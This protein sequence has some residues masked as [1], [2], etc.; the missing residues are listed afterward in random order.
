MLP[1]TD[2]EASAHGTRTPKLAFRP[3]VEGLRAVA[4][5][6]VVGYHAGLP[7]L[8]GG[9][10]G[11]DVFFVISGFLITGLLLAEVQR[12]GRVSLAAFWARRARR[13]LP[14]AVL[15]LVVT[16]VASWL[17]IP[18]IDHAL[19]GGDIVAAGVYVANLRF[20][21]QA[22]DYLGAD[23][24]PSPVLH[25]WSLGV[26]EQF[27]LV[28][29]LLVLAIGVL[30][31][32]RLVA[33]R[34]QAA[35]VEGAGGAAAR[36]ARVA[37][38]VAVALAVVGVA[39]FLYSLW[40]TSESEPWAFFGTPAR[41]WEFAV[42]GLLAVASAQRKVAAPLVRL[43]LGWLGLLVVVG[44]AV[45]LDAD[46]P[47]PG[48][49]ALWPVL[50]TALV[51]AA[52]ASGAAAAR[53]SAPA[54]AGLGADAAL[55]T[56]PMRAVGRLSYSWYLW[57]WPVLVL[58]AAALGPLSVPAK[59]LLVLLAL[60]P[61]ALAYRFIERPVHHA[62]S[63]AGHPRRSLT[64]GAALSALAVVAGLLL[65]SVPGGGALASTSA[66]AASDVEGEA[67]TG[68]GPAAPP[69][70]ATTASP[71]PGASSTSPA[72]RPLP[73]PATG[74]AITPD[75]L[76]ARDDLPVTYENG[77]HLNHGK[78]ASP[79]CVFADT[80]SATRVVLLG[81]SHAAQWFPALEA[82][83]ANRG[84][85]LVS[86]TKSGCPAP[87]VTIWLRSLKR[88]YDECDTWR[89]SVFADLTGADK[90]ALVL[91]T[92]TQTESLVS[93]VD[94][95][96]LDGAPAQQE[97]R[98]GWDRTLERFTAAGVPV[99]VL[100]DTPWPGTD[101]ARCVSEHLDDPSACDVGR[102]ALASPSFDV[103]TTKG[104]DGATPLDLT[105]AMCSAERCPAVIGPRLVYRDD[106]HLT[107][108]F[109]RSLAGRLGVPLAAVIAAGA[110]GG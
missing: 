41:A 26:E 39:S 95:S 68:R 62:A 36:H 79:P 91:A 50:G 15:V 28:W 77:C 103:G 8:P 80:G 10:I 9:F 109:A 74:E 12:T 90:P 104:I 69:P 72:A 88:P 19:V 110:T 92:S 33:A 86:R 78:L 49:A 11:V 100:R 82:A 55:S 75:P 7:F 89:E 56:W 34:A 83:A 98:D 76:V 52:G 25:F 45:R 106:N 84:W 4:I 67:G 44:A 61:S 30:V 96:R 59:V 21:G 63:L 57:H 53:S 37:V 64:M 66:V 108:T 38:G 102:G 58:A 13:L 99:V 73:A 47:Y 23:R 48:T 20:A 1:T 29:P 85:A 97:W 107:A 43:V 3:D 81:D 40:L 35:D 51:L 87:D 101:V 60:V 32:G 22:T 16:A 17:V 27:Y 42:G 65:V 18:R 93:R 14:A 54:A 6:L 71:S 24:A 105:A 70:P 31:V 2:A 46:V 5:G 94:G